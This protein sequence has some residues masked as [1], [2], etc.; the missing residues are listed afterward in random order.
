[1]F[2][3]YIQT[4]RR[5]LKIRYAVEYFGKIWAVWMA[6]EIPSGTFDISS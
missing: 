1:M 5:E 3:R 4:P 6:H 2:H